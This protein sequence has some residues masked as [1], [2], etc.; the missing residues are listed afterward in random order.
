MW[1]TNSPYF[2]LLF[3]FFFSSSASITHCSYAAV[4][5]TDTP[6]LASLTTYELWTY[7]RPW[8]QM[9]SWLWHTITNQSRTC[10]VASLKSVVVWKTKKHCV[11]VFPKSLVTQSTWWSWIPGSHS[12]LPGMCSLSQVSLKHGAADLRRRGLFEFR[13]SNSSVFCAIERTFAWCLDGR[14]AR[15]PCHLSLTSAPARFSPLAPSASPSESW[16]PLWLWLFWLSE[17]QWK[18]SSSSMLKSSSL[19][20]DGGH[21]N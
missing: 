11:L 9:M 3:F 1:R 17:H 20:W 19:W 12:V 18:A 6:W 21:C 5:L 2:P 7:E 13:S 10:S 4:A 16:C 15:N 14:G 8:L